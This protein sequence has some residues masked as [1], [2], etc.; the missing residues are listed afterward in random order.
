MNDVSENVVLFSDMTRLPVSPFLLQRGLCMS[1]TFTTGM[2]MLQVIKILF[3]PFS[4][5]ALLAWLWIQDAGSWFFLQCEDSVVNLG[6]Q[7]PALSVVL[8][9]CLP[10]RV[11]LQWDALC[12]VS[13]VSVV[14][15][16]CVP[17]SSR[18]PEKGSF[19]CSYCPQPHFPH[20]G[21]FYAS[22]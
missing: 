19:I 10:R 9:S 22:Y 20:L 1:Q 14:G 2:L 5:P 12:G 6:C 15:T 17:A 18:P 16:G 13:E 4:L 8:P 3:P 7:A 11:A 21:F